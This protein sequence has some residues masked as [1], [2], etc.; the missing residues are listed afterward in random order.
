MEAP[1]T[2]V[3]ERFAGSAKRRETAGAVLVSLVPPPYRAERDGTPKRHPQ[4]WIT[5]KINNRRRA[6]QHQPCPRCNQPTLVGPDHD[7]CATTARV[8]P[9]PVNHIH[10][11]IALLTGHA[12]FDLI[13]G[14]LH[15]RDHEH[16]HNTNQPHPI[17]LEHRCEK[18]QLW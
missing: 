10:E 11:V 1:E 9:N 14:E 4:K 13:K 15:H 5:N 8:D 3:E 16:I 18:G 2:L 6:A 17:H 7:T 12:S